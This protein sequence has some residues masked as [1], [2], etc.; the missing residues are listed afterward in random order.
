MNNDTKVYFPG[1]NGLRFYAALAVI[2]THIELMKSKLGYSNI[3]NEPIIHQLGVK[4]VS[5]FFVLSGFLITYLLL[6]ERQ[7]TNEISLKHFYIR[8]ILRIWPLYYFLF[9]LGFFVFPNFDFFEIPFFTDSFKENYLWNFI[10][11]LIIFPNLAFSIFNAVPLIGQSWSIGVEE[12][13]YIIWPIILKFKKTL[14]F[15]FL[16][17]ILIFLII[18]KTIVLIAYFYFDSHLTQY[19]K[20]F[21]AMAKFENMIIGGIGALILKK[22]MESLLAVIKKPIVLIFSIS[23][24]FI[25]MYV[26]PDFLLDGIHIINSFLFLIIIIN[27]SSNPKSFLKLENRLYNLL[28]KISYGI[29]MYHLIVVFIVIQLFE[30]INL[31]NFDSIMPNVLLYIF[32]IGFTIFISYISYNLIEIKFLKMK[33]KYTKINSGKL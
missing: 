21:A 18:I 15:K 4:G 33:T 13:F 26:L 7:K 10:F 27:V 11:Y 14:T 22:N 20:N 2:I 3:W 1:L 31:T 16:I 6:I 25:T 28:G 23:F 5:F 32:T 8:R 9:I 24:I 30:K 17:S 19:I 12:Q 29:Y